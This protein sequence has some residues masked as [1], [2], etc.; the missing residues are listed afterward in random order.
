MDEISLL[1]LI[2]LNCSSFSPQK[3]ETL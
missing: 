3:I 1:D 2:Q